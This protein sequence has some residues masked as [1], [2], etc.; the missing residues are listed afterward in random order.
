MKHIKLTVLLLALLLVLPLAFT[1]C[2]QSD[3]D[4]AETTLAHR[5]RRPRA[6]ARNDP[7]SRPQRADRD[8]MAQLMD[9]AQN[10]TAEQ[11]LHLH[12]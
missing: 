4:S 7:R 5:H 10:G 3:S 6:N 11:E 1:G 9:A 2:G 8:G 12:D